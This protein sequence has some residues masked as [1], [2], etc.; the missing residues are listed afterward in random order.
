MS[1]ASL[2]GAASLWDGAADEAFI[3]LILDSI[4][5]KSIVGAAR[6]LDDYDEVAQCIS[7]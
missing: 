3:V 7:L 4:A 6:Y 2:H 5:M 1:S